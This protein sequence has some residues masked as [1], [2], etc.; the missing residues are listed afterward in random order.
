MK[1][2]PIAGDPRFPILAPRKAGDWAFVQHALYWLADYG[3][4]VFVMFP[5][6][7]YRGNAERKIREDLVRKNLVSSVVQLPPGLFQET[8][9]A[10][11]IVVFKEISDGVLFLDAST[12]SLDDES[13]K[14]IVDLVL[15]RE[16]VDFTARL[17]TLDEIERNDFNL[18]VQTYVEPRDTREKIDIVQLEE[19]IERHRR[20]ADQLRGEIDALLPEIRSAVAVMHGGKVEDVH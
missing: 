18:S 1:W 17:A 15:R 4:A 10:T 11:S 12:E 8:S 19:E 7:L 13:R 16:N 6:T 20:R 9:I 2:E 3:A 14:R 5:G